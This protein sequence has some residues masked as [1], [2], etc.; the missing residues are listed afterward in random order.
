LTFV[1][2]FQFLQ[3]WNLSEKKDVEWLS[4]SRHNASKE[5]ATEPVVRNRINL[6]STT[7]N[8]HYFRN[9]CQEKNIGIFL[10]DEGELA[11]RRKRCGKGVP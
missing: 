10:E 3:N 4:V 6:F 1:G 9:S 7:T 2:S 8:K 5:I 11:G